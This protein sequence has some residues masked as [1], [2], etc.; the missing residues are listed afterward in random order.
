MNNRQRA[1]NN[2]VRDKVKEVFAA[3]RKDG[4]V[5]RVNFQD[6]STTACL[7][8]NKQLKE[9]AKKHYV[10]FWHRADEIYYQKTGYLAIRFG[11]EGN[12]KEDDI[13]AACKIVEYLTKFKVVHHWTGN[14][15][16]VI[17]AFDSVASKMQY[18]TKR[19]RRE[20]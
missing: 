5:A 18:L 16:E 19:T 13:I 20:N 17:Y 3:L 10:V 14:P 15:S 4:F 11:S 2:E 12:S 8:L 1:T 6:C 9:D 7:E